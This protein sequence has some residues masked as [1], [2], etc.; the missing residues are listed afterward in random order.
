MTARGLAQD[1]A[2]GMRG[3]CPR[4]ELQAAQVT[5][6]VGPAQPRRKR[7]ESMYSSGSRVGP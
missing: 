5:G 7:T 1:A 2:G 3:A 4:P 6:S